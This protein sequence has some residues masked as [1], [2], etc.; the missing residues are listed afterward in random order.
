MEWANVLNILE[1]LFEIIAGGFAAICMLFLFICAITGVL[2]V[3]LCAVNFL[4]KPFHVKI[5]SEHIFKLLFCP[6]DLIS[7]MWKK[8]KRIGDYIFIPF[9]GCFFIAFLGLSLYQCY[10]NH[11]NQNQNEEEIEDALDETPPRGVPSRYW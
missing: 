5:N 11:S 2:Y 3:V 6:L 4:L 10:G 1:T 8:R 9:M 7:K